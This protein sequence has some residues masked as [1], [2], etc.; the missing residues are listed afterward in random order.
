MQKKAPGLSRLRPHRGW[1]AGRR[2][3]IGRRRCQRRTS[4]LATLTVIVDNN[5]L[6]L[7]DFIARTMEIEPWLIKFAAFGFRRTRGDGHSTEELRAVFDNFD[8][9]GDKPHA[10]IAAPSRG[11]GFRL[12]RMPGMASADSNGSRRG[13]RLQVV[14]SMSKCLSTRNT[15]ANVYGIVQQGY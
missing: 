4:N 5:Q 3:P 14:G 2:N 1:R 15:S 9:K 11:K 8:Y 7:I 12:W 6:Q 10:I 13:S